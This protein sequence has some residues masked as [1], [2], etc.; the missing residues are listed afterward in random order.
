MAHLSILLGDSCCFF[1]GRSSQKSLFPPSALLHSCLC[2]QRR[3]IE[4]SQCHHRDAIWPLLNSLWSLCIK[5][6][7]QQHFSCTVI[8]AATSEA[9]VAILKL[10]I[11]WTNEGGELPNVTHLSTLKIT[12]FFVVQNSVSA[13]RTDKLIKVINHEQDET[14]AYKTKIIAIFQEDRNSQS[15]LSNFWL[16]FSIGRKSHS[17]LHCWS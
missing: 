10:L 13:A 4:L 11:K 6:W 17:I 1:S 9:H 8:T 2:R 14:L 7:Y 5:R 16:L 15:F 12:S 3:K